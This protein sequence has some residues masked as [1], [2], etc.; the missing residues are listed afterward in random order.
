MLVAVSHVCPHDPQLESSVLV[1]MHVPVPQST[2][3]AHEQTP[4]THVL[5]ENVAQT[6]PHAPQLL[7]SVETSVHLL[8]PPNGTVHSF[9]VPGHAHTP[10]THV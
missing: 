2:F 5:P 7:L 8:P 1:S 9:S 4:A 6:T 10:A 3:G